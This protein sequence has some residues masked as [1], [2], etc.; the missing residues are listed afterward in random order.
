MCST[1]PTP[2]KQKWPVVYVFLDCIHAN[3]VSR[4]DFSMSSSVPRVLTSW[5]LLLSVPW[6]H[7]HQGST[8]PALHHM[9]DWIKERWLLHVAHLLYRLHTQTQRTFKHIHTH[10]QSSIY[11]QQNESVDYTVLHKL[12]NKHSYS[13]VSNRNEFYVE[14]S[15]NPLRPKTTELSYREIFCRTSLHVRMDL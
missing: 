12:Q 15:L 4:Y 9:L 8:K 13:E 5:T 10:V 2:Q 14:V 7:A 6:H 1:K 3:F 11:N